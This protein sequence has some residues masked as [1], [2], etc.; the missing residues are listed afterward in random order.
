MV[1]PFVAEISNPA[2]FPMFTHRGRRIALASRVD[3]VWFR[4]PPLRGAPGGDGQAY[5]PTE[6][7]DDVTVVPIPQDC[8]GYARAVVTARGPSAGPVVSADPSKI[9]SCPRV[10]QI[11]TMRYGG[12]RVLPPPNAQCC[13]KKHTQPPQNLRFGGVWVSSSFHGHGQE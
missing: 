11:Q 8:V 1:P 5:M 4:P 7:R 12:D 13:A 6:G 10:V 9:H 2:S 3:D